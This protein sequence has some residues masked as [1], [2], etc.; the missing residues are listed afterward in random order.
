MNVYVARRSDAQII[1]S[2]SNTLPG[3]AQVIEDSMTD[4]VDDGVKTIDL[5]LAYN[6]DVR[7]AC[8]CGNYLLIYNNDGEYL[9]FTIMNVE[10]SASD[11]TVKLYGED[12]GLDLLNKVAGQWKPSSNQTLQQAIQNLMGTSYMG[13][14]VDYGSSN[15]KKKVDKDDLVYESDA[16]YLER[17]KDLITHWNVEFYFSYEIDGFNMVERILHFTP[18]RGSKEVTHTFRLGTDISE[19][20]ETASI[21]DTANVYQIYGKD[22]K[23]LKKL[24]NYSKY[25]GKA[26]RPTDKTFSTSRKC[27]YKI[28]GNQVQ[29]IDSMKRWKSKMDT[30]GAIVRAV[31]TEY[32]DAKSAIQYCMRQ[33]EKIQDT[34]YE[35][36]IKFDAIPEGV[37]TGDYVNIVDETDELYLKARVLSWTKSECDGS[38]EAT[39]GDYTKLRGSKATVRSTTN[40]CS[41]S[42]TKSATQKASGVY[43]TELIATVFWQGQV[44][45]SIDGM[46]EGSSL[47]WYE[48][49]VE[50]PSTDT[51]LDGFKLNLTGLNGQHVYR[52]D[53]AEEV[54]EEED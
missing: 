40:I 28:N 9:L 42:L 52:V 20:T 11:Q 24:K 17:L 30:D 34:S 37:S 45:E 4:S 19:L 36:T 7:S 16:T 29:C 47:K 51:R 2:T 48:D 26:Y 25:S 50:I 14:K 43:N 49:D 21:E 46:P 8:V 10:Y 18:S 13:Y 38:Y 27:T 22:N 44:I 12:A 31:Y 1:Y 15:Y 6:E 23:G 3:N 33:I 35:Y 53:I 41:V 5:T 54:T 32:T 39:I